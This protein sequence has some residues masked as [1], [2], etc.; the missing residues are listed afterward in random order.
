MVFDYVSHF[1]RQHDTDGVEWHGG[2]GGGLWVRKLV[3]LMDWLKLVGQVENFGILQMLV[4]L[5]CFNLSF[6]YF[7]Q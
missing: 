1:P 4:P 3:C 7:E 2:G 6:Q 5:S